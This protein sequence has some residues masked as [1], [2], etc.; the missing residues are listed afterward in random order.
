MDYIDKQHSLLLQVNSG[1]RMTGTAWWMAPELV[2]G[3]KQS[4]AASE[5]SDVWSVGATVVEMLTGKRPFYE[6]K[7]KMAVI[8]ALGKRTLSL[9]ELI[10]GPGFSD[11]VQE[12][13]RLCINWEPSQRATV[14][15]LLGT[16]FCSLE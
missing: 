15:E 5:K 12:F 4:D 6:Y 7:E 3:G 8:F 10:C 14:A 11:E 2:P 1:V 13:L 9:E 16:S